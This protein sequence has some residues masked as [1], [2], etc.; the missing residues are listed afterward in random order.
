MALFKGQHSEE[1]EK[2]LVCKITNN[3]YVFHSFLLPTKR[4]GGKKKKISR[5]SH[6]VKTNSG[7]HTCIELHLLCYIILQRSWRNNNWKNSTFLHRLN[8]V[9]YISLYF[10][11]LINC[12]Q[13]FHHS[14][15]V[16]YYAGS[17]SHSTTAL[18]HWCMVTMI[19]G[20]S[21]LYLISH[22][23]KTC[24]GKWFIIRLT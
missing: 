6:H 21:I 4:G 20:K 24:N 8:C 16:L 15:T 14:V 23:V 13:L 1:C 19:Y 3:S 22:R 2:D 7:S 12:Y 9:L 11:I 5:T 17:L 10:I 18:H